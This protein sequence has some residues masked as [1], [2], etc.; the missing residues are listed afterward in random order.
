MPQ[1]WHEFYLMAGLAAAVLAGLLFVVATLTAHHNPAVSLRTARI[2]VTPTVFHFTAVIVV[3]AAALV[4]STKTGLIGTVLVAL[5]VGGLAYAASV[6]HALYA[7]HRPDMSHW[8]DPVFY[9]LL[10]ALVYLGLIG[11][12]AAFFTKMLNAPYFAGTAIVALIVLGVRDTWDVA[13]WGAT[14]PQMT[15]KATPAKP[16]PSASEPPPWA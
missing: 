16:A 14:H 6:A 5:G 10:P 15:A 1:T 9:A 13:L 8:T 3:S 2:Y 7:R 12:G 11:A 4:P